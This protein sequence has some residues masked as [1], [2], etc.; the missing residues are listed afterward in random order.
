MERTEQLWGLAQRSARGFLRRFEDP[1]TRGERDDLVQETAW[2]AWRWAGSAR[3]PSRFEAA[4]RTIA[5]RARCR[6]L[7]G[8]HRRQKEQMGSQERHG[9]EPST[10]AIAGHRVSLL[11]LLGCLQKVLAELRELDRHLLMGLHEGFCCAELA[12][13]FHLTEQSV[14]VRIHR[15]RRRVQM[16]I[17]RAVLE[18]D[19]LDGVFDEPKQGDER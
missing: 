14:K 11:W 6:M 7:D 8:A 16:E 1:L 13:R 17:E 9:D 15:T 2:T 18:A 19:E 10:F 3:D 4:V 5:R 12:A